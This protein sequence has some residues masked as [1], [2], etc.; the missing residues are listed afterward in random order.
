M[1][2]Q[3][4]S[5]S[6]VFLEQLVVRKLKCFCT[7]FS[8]DHPTIGIEISKLKDPKTLACRSL[9][10]YSSDDLHCKKGRVY[11]RS[12]VLQLQDHEQFTHRE[13]GIG[14]VTVY[15][16]DCTECCHRL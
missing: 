9:R 4:N 16:G 12:R 7:V 10:L 15:T 5:V 1:L 14:S 11:F 13:I 8:T 6:A 3:F 2:H